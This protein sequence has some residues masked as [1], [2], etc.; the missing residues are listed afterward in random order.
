[1]PAMYVYG[2]LSSYPERYLGGS[3]GITM[4]QLEEL[5]STED[6]SNHKNIYAHR[7][8]E[9]GNPPRD[10]QLIELTYTKEI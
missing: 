4:E 3:F 9:C 7:C 5:Q 2:R 6:A 8:P 1:M 10:H